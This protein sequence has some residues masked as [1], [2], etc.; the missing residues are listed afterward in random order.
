MKKVKG[1][2]SKKRRGENEW[3]NNR[4]D[5]LEIQFKPAMKKTS[6]I[7]FISPNLPAQEKGNEEL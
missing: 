7:L 2:P 6:E 5:N 3:M 4:K 1:F